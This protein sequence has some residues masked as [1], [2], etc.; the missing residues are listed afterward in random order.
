M[1]L[2]TTTH[3]Q[4]SIIILNWNR[5]EDT[6][7]CLESA[8][9]NDYPDYR[10]IVV[11]N[12]SSD[13]SMEYLKAWAEGRLNRWIAPDNPLRQLSYPPVEKPLPYF[14]YTKDEA[15]NGGNPAAEKA[16]ASSFKRAPLIFIQAGDNLGYAGGNN[17][18]IRHALSKD[19]TYYIWLLNNDTVI[20]KGALLSLESDIQSSKE[21]GAAGSVLL[22]YSS[23]DVIQTVGGNRFFK[24]FGLTKSIFKNKEY[25]EL[26][27]RH[28]NKTE[29]DYISGCSLLLKRDV[30]ETIGLMDER[31]FAYW[32]D[33]DLGERIKRHGYK[34]ISSL[35]S[36]V[37][38]K[39]SSSSSSYF[40][41]YLSTRN[42]FTFYSKHYPGTLP[43]I[44]LI[45]LFIVFLI[46]FKNVDYSYI[47]GALKG[48]FVFLSITLKSH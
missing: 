11:D 33:A 8:L 35:G 6:I 25:N 34:S 39:K 22:S 21:C 9:R 28:E 12:N 47:R 18:G 2:K 7:E 32:E 48:Y 17:V 16:A 26:I 37:Y 19:D 23:P 36:R 30:L 14:V 43:F 20:D 38:H 4:T 46:G 10:V 3:P 15:L 41:S 42:C 31:Y 13:N 1:N 45:R 44:L 27:E 40:R 24:F 5:W 29:I